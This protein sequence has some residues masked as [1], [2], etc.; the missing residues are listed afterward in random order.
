MV[1]DCAGLV[2]R[3]FAV[4]ENTLKKL[5]SADLSKKSILCSG[6]VLHATAPYIMHDLC[7]RQIHNNSTPLFY[8]TEDYRERDLSCI[9]V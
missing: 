4:L 8:D 5:I 7:S 1:C 9:H 6:F 3:C 2:L